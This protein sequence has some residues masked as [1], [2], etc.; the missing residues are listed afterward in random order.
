M[1]LKIQYLKSRPVGKVTFH[2]PSEAAR[3]ATT[4][5]LVGEF[6]DWDES[7]TPMQRLRDGSFKAT[8]ELETGHAYRYR[9]L[10]DNEKWENDWDAHRYESSAFAGADD[11][12]V[13]V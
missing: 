1:S 8:L 2:L 7:A 4:V 13:D 5:H 12:V 10:I 11:S 9:Y 3:E 6:N